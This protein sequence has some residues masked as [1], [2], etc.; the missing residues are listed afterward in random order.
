MQEPQQ[1]FESKENLFYSS[2]KNF[3]INTQKTFF[4]ENK[5]LIFRM[6]KNRIDVILMKQ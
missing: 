2:T 6:P 3:R 1:N 4:G 5:R